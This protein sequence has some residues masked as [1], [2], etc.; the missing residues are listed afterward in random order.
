MSIRRFSMGLNAIVAIF[1][2]TLI[3]TATAAQQETVLHSFRQ[4]GKDGVWSYASLIFDA[5]GNL[6]GTTSYG[7]AY[8]QG[9]VFEL[10]PKAGGGWMEKVLH[11]FGNGKDGVL[12]FASLVFDA[13]GNLYGTTSSGGDGS[14]VGLTPGC[15]LVFELKPGAGGSWTEKILHN[16]NNN[17]TDGYNPNSGLI[18]DSAGNLFGTT[19]NGGN[20]PCT[21]TNSGCGIVYE[22]LL[23]A[24]G[25]WAEKVVHNFNSNGSDGYQPNAGLI[26]DTVGNLYGTTTYGGNPGPGAVFELKPTASG[27]WAEKILH[28]FS[29]SGTDGYYPYASLIFD[30][31]GNLYGTTASGGA[32]TFYGTVFELVATAG[33]GWTEK[34]L[35]SFNSVA[36]GFYP[37]T[38]PIFDAAGNLYGTTNNGGSPG[39]GTV[40]E[41]MPTLGGGWTEKVLYS[42][43]HAR[44]DGVY[45]NA[46]VIFD[47]AR[48]LYGTTSYGATTDGGTVFQISH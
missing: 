37:N 40:F 31:A 5:S 43:D 41:L 21:A 4:N 11:S 2:T 23:Q 24:N 32:S 25:S 47:A 1:A 14:C 9:T 38:T 16:F 28:N 19:P 7:G 39:P 34:I 22:L 33:G 12:P 13:F 27:L 26:F 30:A 44:G 36:G 3:V 45:P 29:A 8:N 46:G 20:G 17:G 48:N 15:G 6:Y 10:S 42:F 18:F 35:H